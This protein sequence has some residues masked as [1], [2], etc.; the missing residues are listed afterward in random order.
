[1]HLGRR[2]V[3]D[4]IDFIADRKIDL[5]I[6]VGANVGQFGESLRTQGYRG[7]IVSFEPVE[8]VFRALQGKAA[9]DG[10]WEAHHCGLGARSG[11]AAIHVSE[12]S[13]FSSLLPLVSTATQH[14][15]RMAT[16]YSEQAE[17]KTLD[18]VAATLPGRMLL[19]ID[20]QGYERQ[21]IEGGGG[22]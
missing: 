15:R 14:D 20:T 18:E 16:E 6:D 22:L 2:R 3:R 5:V 4:L 11:S 10:N 8:A 1:M 21:V 19:K 7:R 13:V 17:I 12:L 9:A